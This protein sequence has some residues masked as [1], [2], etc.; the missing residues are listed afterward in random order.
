MQNTSSGLTVVGAQQLLT[1]WLAIYTIALA[2]IVLFLIGFLP[3]TLLLIVV[4]EV[5]LLSLRPQPNFGAETYAPPAPAEWQDPIAALRWVGLARGCWT[6]GV[7]SLALGAA[8]IVLTIMLPI[9]AIRG[10]PYH[11]GP[12]NFI[13]LVLLGAWLASRPLWITPLRQALKVRTTRQ[14][15]KFMAAISVIQDGV[16]IDIRPINIGPLQARQH[17]FRVAFAELDE[18]RAMDGLS[19]Q[20]YQLS[21]ERYDPTLMLRVEWEL[22]RFLSGQVARPTLCFAVLGFGTHVLIRSSTLLY[23]I[24]NA[25]QSAPTIVAAWQAWNSARQT[26]A[27][28]NP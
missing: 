16:S 1:R 12:A 5:V 17:E 19:A 23:L 7:F 13:V 15:A 28:P 9:I 25:D 11:L 14:F 6:L 8:S 21:M 27:T 18:V 10:W 20:G 22:V 26:S 2:G 4:S 24:G 3:E